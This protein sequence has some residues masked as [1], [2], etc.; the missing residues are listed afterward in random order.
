MRVAHGQI[1]Y[2][3]VSFYYTNKI[4]NFVTL[5]QLWDHLKSC[6]VDYDAAL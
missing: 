1:D 6:V 5:P 2:G 4:D 3:K